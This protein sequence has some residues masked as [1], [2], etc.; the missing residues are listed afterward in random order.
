MESGRFLP[1]KVG[2]G[3]SY[4]GKDDLFFSLCNRFSERAAVGNA[5]LFRWRRGDRFLEEHILISWKASW[6]FRLVESL[7]GKGSI[8]V[9]RHLSVRAHRERRRPGERCSGTQAESRSG[10]PGPIH[11]PG[12][13]GFRAWSH[14]GPWA[15][16]VS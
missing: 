9:K 7:I 12:T 11:C 5:F 15:G 1:I 14:R 8:R 2:E 3:G 10:V 13:A 6:Q 4:F 16:L